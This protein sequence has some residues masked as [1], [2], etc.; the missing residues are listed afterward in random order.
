M[1]EQG[2]SS[3]CS[4][5]GKNGAKKHCIPCKEDNVLC[6][7][8]CNKDCQRKHWKEHRK[9]CLSVEKNKQKAT[10]AATAA[11]T[12]SEASSKDDWKEKER[13]PM[14]VV[15]NRKD[16]KQALKMQI[17]FCA[18]CGTVT[19]STQV[20]SRCK[21]STYCSKECQ[22][23]HWPSHKMECRKR[24]EVTEK[25]GEVQN[26][27]LSKWKLGAQSI[28]AGLVR[29][30]FTEEEFH[31]QPCKTVLLVVVEFNWNYKTF[32]PVEEPM[33]APIDELPDNL[34]MSVVNYAQEKFQI[35]RA[36][37]AVNDVD[38]TR[39]HCLIL[40]YKNIGSIVPLKILC[41]TPKSPYNDILGI[42][43]L[44]YV[45]IPTITNVD[46]TNKLLANLKFQVQHLK[47]RAADN[48][49]GLLNHGL[50]L[51]TKKPRHLTHC[52]MLDLEFGFDLGQI[53]GLEKFDIITLPNARDI[54]TQG[55]NREEASHSLQN[56]L[57]VKRSPTLLASRSRY[58]NNILLPVLIVN[59]TTGIV[60]VDPNMLEYFPATIRPKLS[61]VHSDTEANLHFSL[62]QTAA[63]S[64]P[65]VASPSLE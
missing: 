60:I 13:D 7:V 35:S 19:Q 62:L 14:V 34:R 23:R 29:S 43:K 65:P 51:C 26:D 37:T 53:C 63:K 8:Y 49:H 36:A 30:F 40:M 57:D 18:A 38:D 25:L 48:W 55:K 12:A 9:V 64:L 17:R 15:E 44:N 16:I 5:C 47:Q 41:A 52:I 10:A 54:V 39:D 59:K 58:P 31:Q 27:M 4:C 1:V 28:Y 2:Q 46:W 3:S 42:M 21:V 32:L 22:V 56:A 45:K 33:K 24:I 50:R 20:C 11:A 61:A 6:V